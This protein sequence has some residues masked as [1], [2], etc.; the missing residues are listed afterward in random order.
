MSF[1]RTAY[2]TCAYSADILESTGPGKYVMSTPVR[3]EAGLFSADD[4]VRKGRVA[5]VAF[6]SD[7][8]DIDSELRGIRRPPIS[9]RRCSAPFAPLAA[10]PL[11]TTDAPGARTEDTLISN[12]P[13]TLRERG[14]NRWHCL[15]EDPQ[16]RLIDSPLERIGV[17]N[18]TLVKDAHVP[19]LPW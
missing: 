19:C 10:E 11:Q 14:V 18:R 1:N 16:Q 9:L 3:A 5:A 17:N 2:D 8:A 7:W 6:G 4:H 15:L 12:P 13:S